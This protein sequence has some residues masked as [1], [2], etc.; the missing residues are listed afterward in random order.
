MRLLTLVF[1]MTAV[2]STSKA[3]YASDLLDSCDEVAAEMMEKVADDLLNDG[4]NAPLIVEV[5]PFNII[6]PYL[7]NGI[8]SVDGETIDYDYFLYTLDD[9]GFE[10]TAKYNF[11]LVIEGVRCKELAPPRFIADWYCSTTEFEGA[12]PCYRKNG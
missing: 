6:S 5:S 11:E 2:C 7:G 4:S 9:D 8:G 3:N 10:S 12:V 1:L